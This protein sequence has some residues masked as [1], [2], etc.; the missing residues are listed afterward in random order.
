MTPLPTLNQN[1]A[2]TA[3]T[4]SAPLMYPR[5]TMMT[6]ARNTLQKILKYLSLFVKLY[7][8]SMYL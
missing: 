1:P 4:P 7:A 2:A 3:H 5:F 6:A 8:L